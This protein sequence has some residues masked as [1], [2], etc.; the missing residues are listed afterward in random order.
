M[1]TVT[2]RFDDAVYKQIKELAAFH[3]LTPTAFMEN[4]ILEQVEDELDY[5]DAIKVLQES[6]G[7]TVSQ[8]EVMARLGLL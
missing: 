5:Q 6:D 7:E 1:T 8:E 4:T 2:I 3:G